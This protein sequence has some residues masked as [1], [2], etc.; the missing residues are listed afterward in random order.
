MEVE[1]YI[2]LGSNMG[3]RL[4]NIKSAIKAVGEIENIRVIKLS[5]VYETA[6][7]GYVKQGKF[8]NMVIKIKT[9]LSP[10]A[11]LENFQN[12]EIML[13]RKRLIHWGPRTIDL[14]ILTYDDL[15]LSHPKLI[16]PHPEMLKRAF[17]LI[18]LR[19]IDPN[20]RFNGMEIDYYINNC[21]DRHT[22]IL[23]KTT[24]D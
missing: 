4:E 3:N 21:S 20:I 1:A 5:K 9:C 12:I 8:L 13:K 14:D 7:V 22:V 16:I 15:V 11:L 10:W 2:A 23:Y 24:P 19:D 18:P 17:V 6:P